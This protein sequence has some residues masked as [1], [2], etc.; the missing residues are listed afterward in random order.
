MLQNEEEDSEHTL[1]QTWAGGTG[2]GDRTA[3][4]QA[5]CHRVQTDNAMGLEGEQLYSAVPRN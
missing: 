3:R 1:A 2:L 4:Q 5:R